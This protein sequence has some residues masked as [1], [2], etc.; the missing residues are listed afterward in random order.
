MTTNPRRHPRRPRNTIGLAVL[1]LGTAAAAFLLSPL[2][3]HATVGV[4]IATSPGPIQVQVDDRGGTRVSELQ[5]GEDQ[6]LAAHDAETRLRV[7]S[8]PSGKVAYDDGSLRP[9]LWVLTCAVLLIGLL[10]LLGGSRSRSAT[11]GTGLQPS[12]P[13]PS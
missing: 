9:T 6:D 3:P 7:L 11:S 12:R 10:L 4:V 13:E 8:Y 2:S 5:V 1:V